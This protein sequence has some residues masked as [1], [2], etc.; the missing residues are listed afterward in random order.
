M[1][2]GVSA[3]MR[4]PTSLGLGGLHTCDILV[5]DLVFVDDIVDEPPR[6][7]VDDQYLPLRAVSAKAVRD[8]T[9]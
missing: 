6:V 8:G 9:I 2:C 5:Q 4:F 3:G 1:H 7:C